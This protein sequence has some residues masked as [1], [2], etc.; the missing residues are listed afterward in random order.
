MNVKES[1][2]LAFSSIREHKLRA[3]LSLLSIAIGV[4]A[5]FGSGTLT[6]SINTTVQDELNELG[7]N[8]FLITRTPRTQQGRGSW[9]RYRNRPRIKIDQ[10][11][12]LKRM[13]ETTSFISAYIEDGGNVV[14]SPYIESNP[15]V[16]LEGVDENYF[17]NYNTIVDEGRQ[18][19]QQDI[20][21][22]RNVCV[23]GTDI[24]KKLFPNNPIGQK[25]RIKSQ[26]FEIIGILE[27]KGAILGQSQDNRVLLPL[28]QYLK[29]YANWWESLQITVKADNSTMLDPTLDEVIGAMR[30]IRNLKPWEE[31]NF[32]YELNEGISG[33]F[34]GLT[35]YLAIFASL[36]GVFSLIAA[37]IGI[38]NIMLVT[39]KERT[40]EIGVRKA[41]GSKS[42]WILQQFLIETLTLT[43][44]GTFL[45]IVLTL[46]VAY[47]F[48][49]AFNFNL[50]IPIDWIFFSIGI[51][52][53]MGVVSG[54]YPAYK[55]SK[56][57]PIDALRYE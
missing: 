11:D 22:K 8:T 56:L 57:D 2:S 20:V 28:G 37:G 7:E 32:E 3:F 38:T 36:I 5:I 40:R 13:V 10:V 50:V 6:R 46:I 27:E 24:K 54:L 42:R 41:V 4:F 51:T 49:E 48:A 23:I 33:Q 34:E 53:F 1:I 16:K 9:R 18:I 39:I 55:A 21:F 17:V 19:T 15:D 26:E 12:K 52:T 29:Y 14:E 43:Q 44:L 35:K 30:V 25:L 45:G 31:N 47:G